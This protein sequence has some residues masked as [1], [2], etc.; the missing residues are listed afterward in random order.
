VKRPSDTPD[1]ED[2]ALLAGKSRSSVASHGK[3]HMKSG[4]RR[5]A[6]VATARGCP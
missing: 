2:K 6:E 4:R 3:L 5:I 1:R